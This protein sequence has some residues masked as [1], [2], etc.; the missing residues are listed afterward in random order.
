MLSALSW[1]RLLAALTP[2]AARA[3]DQPIFSTFKAATATSQA[4]FEPLSRS[5]DLF[6]FRFKETVRAVLKVDPVLYAGYSLRRGVVTE[7][8]LSG[9]P[10]PMVKRHVGW[11]PGSQAVNAYYDHY[12]RPQM[13]LPT[14]RMGARSA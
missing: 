6:I 8:L 7:M 12:G 13:R 4:R 11:A 14:A 3:P 9:V 1:L 10:V 5:L 2:A